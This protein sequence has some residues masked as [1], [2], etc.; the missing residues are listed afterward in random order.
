[1]F[2][3]K[4]LNALSVCFLSSSLKYLT[5]SKIV[6][7]QFLSLAPGAVLMPSALIFSSFGWLSLIISAVIRFF[8]FGTSSAIL[9]FLSPVGAY[10]YYKF[11]TARLI[12]P[13]ICMALFIYHPTGFAAYNYG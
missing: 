10:L 7:A 4:V 8:F 6:G 5:F 1:M 9:A 12:L 11:R 3:K 2:I 13:V